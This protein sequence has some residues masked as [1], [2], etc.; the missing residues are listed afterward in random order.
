MAESSGSPPDSPRPSQKK[1]KLSPGRD[2]AAAQDLNGTGTGTVLLTSNSKNDSDRNPDK[3]FSNNKNFSSSADPD[4]NHDDD[5]AKTT[6]KS[7]PGPGP[8]GSSAVNDFYVRYYIGHRGKFGHEF[9]EFEMQGNGRLR[10]ANNSNYKVAPTV[11]AQQSTNSSDPTNGSSGATAPISDSTMIKK[12]AFVS[13]LVVHTLKTMVEDSGIL[14]PGLSDAKW[15]EP[16]SVGSQELEILCGR[17]HIS[18]STCKIGKLKDVQESDDP[19]GLRKFYYLVQDL[20]CYVFSLMSLHFRINP[21]AR[22]QA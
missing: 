15:P 16:N 6:I 12:E 20:K 17:E 22:G 8:T 14:S 2:S 18:F 13:P 1:A 5:G 3:N 4:L 19:E 10:Y 21:V 11:L 7:G 9:L